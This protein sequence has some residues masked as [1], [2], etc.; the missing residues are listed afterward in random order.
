MEEDAVSGLRYLKSDMP[1]APRFTQLQCW[2]VCKVVLGMGDGF[3]NRVLRLA[4]PLGIE[5]SACGRIP[6]ASFA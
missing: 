4:R 6:G 2:T 3:K 1:K 5:S